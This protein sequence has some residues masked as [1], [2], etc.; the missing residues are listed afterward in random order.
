M[1][2]E[3]RRELKIIPAQVKVVK[4]IRYIYSCRNCEKNDIK[5]PVITAKM[6][7][8]V[9]PGSFVSPSLMSFVMN[10]KYSESI[11]LYR[12]EQ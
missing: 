9:L 7:A 4:H 11:L 1:S 2:K 8:A 12:Q 10:R 5:T 6:P 3:V